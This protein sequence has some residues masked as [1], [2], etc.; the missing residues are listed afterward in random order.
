[1]EVGYFRFELLARESGCTKGGTLMA[2][3]MKV[4]GGN[5]DGKH[6]VVMACGSITE[7]YRLTGVTYGYASSTGNAEEVAA[8]MAEPGIMFAKNDSFS[9][10]RSLRRIGLPCNRLDS[11]RIVREAFERK[12]AR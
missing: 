7:F 12:A 9:R 1:V 5:L 4:F 11:F 10:D 2:R 6:R 8:A 3:T